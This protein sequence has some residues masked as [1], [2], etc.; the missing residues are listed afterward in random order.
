MA[1][2]TLF[3]EPAY[4]ADVDDALR[5][6]GLRDYIRLVR[7]PLGVRPDDA[8]MGG[9]L[10]LMRIG[11]MPRAGWPIHDLQPIFAAIRARVGYPLPVERT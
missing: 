11:P 4:H 2:I 9:H 3:V 1:R 6:A 7:C 10:Q 5:S 8:A